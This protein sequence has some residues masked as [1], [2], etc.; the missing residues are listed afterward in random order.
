MHIPVLLKESL[1]YLNATRPGRFIDGTAGDGGHTIAILKANSEN[2]VLALDWD[3]GAAESLK[4]KLREEKLDSRCA[5]LAG[6]YADLEKIASEEFRLVN[7]VILDLG[8]SS[9]QIDDPA[10]GFSFQHRGPLD[11]RYDMTRALR[12]WD[13]VNKYPEQKLKEIIKEYGEER[14]G[15]KVASAIVKERSLH[16]ID[17]TLRLYEIIKKALPKPLQ[18]KAADSARRVFQ[19]I[20]IEVNA[21]LENLKEALPQIIKILAPG[22][23]LVVISFHSL[24]D[25]IA[26]WFLREEA[27]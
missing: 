1:E 6:N 15:S 5:V 21:E 27:A 16:S 8:F 19:G 10:R 20:R 3:A 22:G 12:A 24:E 11:M 26:K 7:G 13:M 9:Q 14:F 23:R 25:R 17:D 4:E 2:K 18:Y